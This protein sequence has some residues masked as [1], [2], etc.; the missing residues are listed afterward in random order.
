M[1]ENIIKIAVNGQVGNDTRVVYTWPD[2]FDPARFSARDEWLRSLYDPREDSRGFTGN[3]FYALWKNAVGNYYS[4]IV[5]NAQD[6]R[7][8]WLMLTIYTGRCIFNDGHSV[9]EAFGALEPLLLSG[10]P[11]DNARVAQVVAGLGDKLDAD[12]GR[13]F[14]GASR[15]KG[16]R[17]YASQ[18]DVETFFAWPNQSDYTA[19]QRIVLVP[20]SGVALTP[21]QGFVPINTPIRRSF[22]VYTTQ[23]GIEV[24]KTFVEQGEMITINY[25]RPTFLPETRQA[26]VNGQPCALLAYEGRRLRILTPEEAGISF[27]RGVRLKCL[28][29]QK[30]VTAFWVE[31]DGVQLGRQQGS[32]LFILP[33]VQDAYRLTVRSHGYKDTTILVQP[34]HL[35]GAVVKVPLQK[36][37]A[38]P[39]RSSGKKDQLGLWIAIAACVVVL[40]V[41]GVSAAYFFEWGPFAKEVPEDKKQADV[42]GSAGYDAVE[43]GK[44]EKV[45]QAYMKT[46]D[47]WNVDSIHSQ[48]Y[49]QLVGLL[50]SGEIDKI[51]DA[52]GT[53]FPEG[54]VNGY[55][56][57]FEEMIAKLPEGTGMRPA[58]VTYKEGKEVIE[59][60]KLPT[61]GT[62]EKT[63]MPEDYEPEGIEPPSTSH[64]SEGRPSR[65]GESRPARADQD[66]PSANRPRQGTNDNRKP[67]ENSAS[68]TTKSSKDSHKADDATKAP[69]KDKAEAPA[70]KAS[71]ESSDE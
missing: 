43:Q 7:A 2:A 21:P 29:G 30:P 58:C 18:Q 68:Q 1:N 44:L 38:P 56:K 55:W 26:V 48:K 31:L 50:K 62:E 35:S 27:R 17:T 65:E 33:T 36:A 22:A 70:P 13:P 60:K 45:D 67:S 47:E 59:L 19:F 14:T 57:K 42:D 11:V 63:P 5:P 10:R 25:Q 52:A 71:R 66:R 6:A 4:L 51:A 34:A 53:W 20:A 61:D 69:K 28:A 39:K 3:R 15:Q 8:G 64:E 37:P 24:S 23:P 40:G 9:M 16:F 12:P 49:K 46:H 32:D 41:A 54:N